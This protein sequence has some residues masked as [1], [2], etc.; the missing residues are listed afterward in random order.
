MIVP[1]TA[2]PQDV[3]GPRPLLD[4]AVADMDELRFPAL[5]DSGAVN[6]LLPPWLADAAGVALGE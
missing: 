6:T 3:G 5:V 4:V 2:L 1:Y